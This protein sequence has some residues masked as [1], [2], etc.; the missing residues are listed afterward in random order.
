MNFLKFCFQISTLLQA[1]FTE[2]PVLNLILTNY[3]CEYWKLKTLQFFIC[4]CN[5]LNYWANSKKIA[6]GPVSSIFFLFS[7]SSLNSSHCKKAYSFDR[8]RRVHEEVKM[9][10]RS[11]Y[12][13]LLPKIFRYF[14][15]TLT[16]VWKNFST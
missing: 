16:L 13:A 12:R 6:P 9:V 2:T 14:T 1:K 3:S 8:N 11:D 4:F 5:F 15:S 7:N 10:Y